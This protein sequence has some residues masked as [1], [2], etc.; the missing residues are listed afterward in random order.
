[1]TIKEWAKAYPEEA[2][3]LFGCP[4][5]DVDNLPAVKNGPGGSEYATKEYVDHM[6][7]KEGLFR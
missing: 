1:M 6:T 2:A 4:V 3:R 5:D 7:E